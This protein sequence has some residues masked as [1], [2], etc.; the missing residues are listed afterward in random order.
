MEGFNRADVVEF[1][2]RL[3]DE[4]INRIIYANGSDLITSEDVMKVF[5]IVKS[6]VRQA[7]IDQINKYIKNTI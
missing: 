2:D 4:A 5:K 1:C 6:S 3:K 7:D